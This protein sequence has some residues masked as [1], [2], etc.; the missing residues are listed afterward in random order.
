M[1][2]KSKVPGKPQPVIMETETRAKLFSLKNPAFILSVYAI[3]VSA[4]SYIGAHYKDVWVFELVLGWIAVAALLLTSG[5]FRF[6]NMAYWLVGVHFLVLA[7]G[8]RYSYAEM[9]LFN[10]LRDTLHLQRNY[11]D[12]VGHFMQGFVP[13]I[14]AREIILRNSKLEKGRLLG[15][16]VVFS[17]LGLSAF[18]ELLEWWMVI[19]IYP[20]EGIAWVGMQGDIWDA[21]QDMLQAFLGA[22]LAILLFSRM[23][24]RSMKKAMQFTPGPA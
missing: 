18:Y 8:A 12:R 17:T 16:L 21:Q 20:K 4:I 15:F 24:D 13:A 23:H 11:Y 1:V 14:V 10:W 22:T 3:I 6:S 19:F 2:P 5:R 7:I 9:P